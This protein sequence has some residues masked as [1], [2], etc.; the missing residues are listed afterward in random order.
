VKRLFSALAALYSGD[1]PP[2]ASV[3]TCIR[4]LSPVPPPTEP[5]RSSPARARSEDARRR[6]NARRSPSEAPVRS[7]S[8]FFDAS[9]EA[10]GATGRARVAPRADARELAAGTTTL[11]AIDA[12]MRRGED[13]GL[14]RCRIASRDEECPSVGADDDATIA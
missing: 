5:S 2:N 11:I 6:A 10:R 12:N 8:G 3:G 4:P 7:E 9:D 1:M 14:V 13:G